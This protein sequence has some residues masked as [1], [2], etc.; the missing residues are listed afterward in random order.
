M[1]CFHG[2]IPASICTSSK[3]EKIVLSA[4]SL[5]CYRQPKMSGSIPQCMFD[6]PNLSGLYL[7]SNKLK[8]EISENVL[9]KSPLL[10][11]LSIS[12]NMV[13]GKIPGQLM[14]TKL[15]TVDLAHNRL[16]GF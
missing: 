6:M 15:M 4:L 5:A 3:L 8:G 12:Y 14:T 1:N 9:I 11:N 7:S 10:V 16:T 13:E 2:S